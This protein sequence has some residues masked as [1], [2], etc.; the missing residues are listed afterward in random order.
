MTCCKI[1]KKRSKVDPSNMESAVTAI[2]LEKLSYRVMRV[3]FK[4]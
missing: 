2:L 1:K 3:E 4:K